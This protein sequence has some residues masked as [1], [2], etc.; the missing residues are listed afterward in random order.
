MKLLTLF[1]PPTS[2]QTGWSTREWTA[3]ARRAAAR[4]NVQVASEARPR[5]TG[6]R[7][8]VQLC[9]GVPSVHTLARVRQC[10][11]RCVRTRS[12][13]SAA[14]GRC[15]TRSGQEA[16]PNT[17]V[18]QPPSAPPPPSDTRPAPKSPLVDQISCRVRPSPRAIPRY[19][20]HSARKRSTF[21]LRTDA[22]TSW[23]STGVPSTGVPTLRLSGKSLGSAARDPPPGP[24]T[25]WYVVGLAGFEP[26]TS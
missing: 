11:T 26:A 18:G 20:H 8:V 9:P 16:S 21:P 5:V 10:S 14:R 19:A 12:P 7:L 17:S 22:N 3:W 4:S 6:P 13:G 2:R 25:R 15:Q 23:S 24:L 1:G